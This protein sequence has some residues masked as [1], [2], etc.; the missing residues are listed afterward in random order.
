MSERAAIR[1]MIALLWAWT[2]W[3]AT[4]WGQDREARYT[5]DVAQEIEEVRYLRSV[6]DNQIAG[7]ADLT[8]RAIYAIYG[9]DTL[10]VRVL[11]QLE[12]GGYVDA[13]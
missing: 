8:G 5:L 10:L 6:V 13:R 7:A 1:A 12:A 9:R 2:V 4:L 3:M 11:G